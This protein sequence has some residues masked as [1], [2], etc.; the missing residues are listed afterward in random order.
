MDTTGEELTAAE[1]R[2]LEKHRKKVEDFEERERKVQAAL[3][4]LDRMVR[5][6]DPNVQKQRSKVSNLQAGMNKALRELTEA[7]TKDKTMPQIIRKEREI[8]RLRTSMTTRETFSRRELRGRITK[9]YN[10][11]NRRITSPSEK[12]NIPVP[13]MMQA[14]E[15]LEAINMDSTREGSKAGEQLRSK[16]LELQAKYKQLQN[17]PDYRNAAVYDEFV[18]ELLTN[19][20]EEVGD[21]PINRMSASQMKTV[22]DAFDLPSRPARGEWIEM[23]AARTSSTFGRVSPRTGRVD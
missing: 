4:E 2:E 6:K 15:V 17:D 18:A 10:D 22:Y 23:R 12:K 13:V 1:R 14:I 9:L 20:V 8:Q 16:L 21:T 5:A 7:E 19:M 11:L 3:E